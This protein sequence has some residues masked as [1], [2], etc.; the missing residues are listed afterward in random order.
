MDYI[1]Y[2]PVKHGLVS[3]PGAWPWSG[4]ARCVERGWYDAAW[5]S[6]EPEGIVG[7]NLE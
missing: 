5:G 6:V 4:F 1:H 2:N 3:R 7:L